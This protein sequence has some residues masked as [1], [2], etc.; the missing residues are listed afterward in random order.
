MN[1]QLVGRGN[2]T[3][4][5]QIALQYLDDCHPGMTLRAAVQAWNER[6]LRL[7]RRLGF[8]DAGELT[9]V[10]GG[11]SVSYRVL[12]RPPHRDRM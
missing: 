7:T 5:G 1:P 2:G 3:R 6:S 4:F 8:E 12:Q 9:T 11:R 10:Q